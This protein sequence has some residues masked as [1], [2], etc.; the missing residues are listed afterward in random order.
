M[1]CSRLAID[2]LVHRHKKSA[3]YK[4]FFLCL[5]IPCSEIIYGRL[6]P[7]VNRC[8]HA[9]AGC[10]VFLGVVLEVGGFFF[11]FIFIFM[12]YQIIKIVLIGVPIRQ[13]ISANKDKYVNGPY[14]EWSPKVSMYKDNREKGIHK[15][16]ITISHLFFCMAFST[17]VPSVFFR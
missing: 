17:Q 1:C 12:V 10:G 2:N 13:A 11:F 16:P 6:C 14:E 7:S 9:I 15:T 4:R 3:L 5:E 8:S